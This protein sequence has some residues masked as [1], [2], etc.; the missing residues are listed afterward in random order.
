LKYVLNRFDNTALDNLLFSRSMYCL[1]KFK[2]MG[3]TV[4]YLRMIT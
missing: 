4:S 2:K 3:Q 1:V